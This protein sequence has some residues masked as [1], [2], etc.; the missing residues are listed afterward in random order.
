MKKIIIREEIKD[1]TDENF[2]FEFGTKEVPL[3]RSEFI[4]VLEKEFLRLLKI[5]REQK[6]DIDTDDE[7]D[8]GK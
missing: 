1:I 4:S 7:P 6:F 2:D 5:Y 3:E 8:S